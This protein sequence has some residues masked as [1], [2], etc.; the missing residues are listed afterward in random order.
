M[1][2]VRAG[3]YIVRGAIVHAYGECMSPLDDG[4]INIHA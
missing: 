4:T 3:S 2:F 1:V